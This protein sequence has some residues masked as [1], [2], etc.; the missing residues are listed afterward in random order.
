MC[1]AFKKPPAIST[2]IWANKSWLRRANSLAK[3]QRCNILIPHCSNLRYGAGSSPSFHRFQYFGLISDIVLSSSVGGSPVL[4]V[5]LAWDTTFNQVWLIC[6]SNLIPPL[7]FQLSPV[8]LGWVIHM[9][10]QVDRPFPLA[11]SRQHPALGWQ[12]FRGAK[13]EIWFQSL[14]FLYYLKRSISSF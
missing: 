5:P 12:L 3:C 14:R 6:S 2:Q 11:H 8:A 13:I 9:E 7:Q 4:A 1:S 10:S